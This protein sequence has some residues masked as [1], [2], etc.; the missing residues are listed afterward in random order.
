MSDHSKDL[1]R[2]QYSRQAHLYARSRSHARGDTLQLMVQW[3]ECKGT[4]YVLDVATGCG[5]WFREDAYY[6]PIPLP[7]MIW[8]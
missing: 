4:E 3:T 8:A 7:P 2:Q 5:F 6:W 1:V